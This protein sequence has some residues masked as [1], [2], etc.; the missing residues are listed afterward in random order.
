MA[1]PRVTPPIV[2]APR[3]A[4][5][6]AP[7]LGSHPLPP[8]PIGEVLLSKDGVTTTNVPHRALREK[9]GTRAIT[10]GIV[11]NM[12][13]RHHV[14][15]EA[16]E[17]NQQHRDAMVR[18][19]LGTQQNQ[20]SRFPVNSTT[21][22]G[23]LAEIV[24][25]EYVAAATGLSLPVYRLR[26]NP[27]IDQSMKGDD[28]LAFD[29]DAD[30]VRMIVGE[31]KFRGLSANVAV[32]DIVEGLVRSQKGGVPVSLQ[33]VADRLFEQ[34]KPELGQKV[35]E[36]AI[37]IARGKLRLDYV[38]LLL[39]DTRCAERIDASTPGTLRSLAMIS[40]GLDDPDGLAAAC[41]QNLE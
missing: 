38:G 37:L 11:R 28:V 29:L 31:S 10:V 23:N 19:G 14:S 24:L 25:A 32:T 40:V 35:L 4:S 5:V 6:P 27:N 18:L 34:G 1:T 17:R 16:Q 9:D 33:F 36:C 21:R 13:T 3:K 41:F 22:K 39:S 2:P 26:Y 20:L 12:L 8:H 7:I 15:P 30:P